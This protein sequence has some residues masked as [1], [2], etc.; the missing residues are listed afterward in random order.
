MAQTSPTA[1]AVRDIITTTLT[2]PQIEAI[3][4]DAALLVEDCASGWSDAR[5]TSIVKWVAAHMI[6]SRGGSEGMLTQRTLGDASETYAKATAGEM[7]KGSS[8]GQQALMLDTNGCLINL[9]KRRASFKV[10]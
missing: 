10:L 9:G 1:A 5:Y 8:Y 4:A 3:I 7:L 2:D 6:A